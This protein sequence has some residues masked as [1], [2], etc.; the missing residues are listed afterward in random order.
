MLTSA[1]VIECHSDGAVLRLS[2]GYSGNRAVL[3]CFFGASWGKFGC[4]V[5]G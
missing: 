4:F 2:T 5:M 1:I 3:I